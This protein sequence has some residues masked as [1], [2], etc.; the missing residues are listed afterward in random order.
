MNSMT[1]FSTPALAIA[2][3]GLL[4]TLHR[5]RNKQHDQNLRDITP[6]PLPKAYA[7]LRSNSG[8]KLTY[9]PDFLPGAR[10]IDTPYGKTRAY[11]FGPENGTKV[12]LIHGISTPCI[13]VAPLARELVKRG[14]RVLTFDLYGRGYSDNPTY[15]PHSAQLYIS[16]ALSVLASSPLSWTG[17]NAFELIGYS[18]GG[19]IAAAF[20]DCF[21][22]LVNSLVL[23]CPAGLVRDKNVEWQRFLM[24]QTEGLLPT[25]FLRSLLRRRVSALQASLNQPDIDNSSV[26][27]AVAGELSQK[28]A[29]NKAVA[30]IFEAIRWQIENHEGFADAFTSSVRHAPI[31]GQHAAWKRIGERLSQQRKAPD[32]EESQ[33]HGFV[34]NKVIIFLGSE[35]VVIFSAEVEPDAKATVGEENVEAVVFKTG[36][37]LPVVMT[38]K[39]AEKLWVLWTDFGIV[40]KT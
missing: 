9:P 37:D 33:R 15:Q 16:Q 34:G 4:L 40:S 29:D 18:L 8:A 30:P 28:E 7:E 2:T 21:P 25:W 17:D 32:D 27:G 3:I 24:F 12:L 39:V 20:A 19:G 1:G 36:H 22:T 38:E 35:D 14:C 11:E 23:I 5:H 10:D 26:A 31:S 13:S 6:S